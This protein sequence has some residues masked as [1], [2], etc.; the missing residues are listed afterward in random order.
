VSKSPLKSKTLPKKSN[1]IL[2]TME[3]VP[4]YPSKLKFF[5]VYCSK[6][7]WARVYVNGSYKVRSLKT[8]S[9]K[10]AINLTKKFYEEALISD[11]TGSMGAPRN[12]TFSNVG[13]TYIETLNGIGKDRLYKDDLNR[14]KKEL[15]PHFG[16]KDVGL[17]TNADIG[18]LMKKLQLKKLA[19]ATINH[20]I[21]VLR[22]ILNF[23]ADN[24]LIQA[25]PNF[26]KIVG[27][28]TGHT[29][30]D[31]F[32]Q[33]E[34]L[35]LIRT[36]NSL[37]KAGVKVRGVP[38]TVEMKYLIQFMIHS[39][40]RPSDLRVL[41]NQHV[42]I[43]AKEN[44]SNVNFNKYLLLTHPATKT[45]DQ[46]VVTMPRAAAVYNNLLEFHKTRGY[47]KKDDYVFFPNYLNRD[48]MITRAGRLFS[49]IVKESGVG[50]E[51][52]KHT[53]Y[54]LRHTAIMYRLLLGKVNT[55]QLAKNARTSQLMIEKYYA[56]RLTN[57]MGVEELH[58]FKSSDN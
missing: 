46:D 53:L 56:S 25:T 17:I 14:F 10:E 40:I 22:K 28:S 29:K 11:R 43:I 12:R 26:P 45:T 2:E 19:P 50:N 1:A 55:L 37:A 27:K 31:Y 15:V 57:L 38:I 6:F 9:R 23:A 8:E 33:K 51:D 44:E 36:S 32:E 41:K 48:T 58:S 4:G 39:F 35:K 34:Y 13:L 20:Y 24:Q 52:E 18:A 42:K 30:R 16:E 5:K 54:S 49:E 21:V 3:S 7:Y 47:G